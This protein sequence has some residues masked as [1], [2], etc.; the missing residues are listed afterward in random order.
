[1][2]TI[3][4]KYEG[5]WFAHDIDDASTTQYIGY[6]DPDGIWKIVKYDS[7]ADQ[8][9]LATD[10]NNPAVLNYPAAW[11]DRATLVYEYI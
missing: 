7:V 2:K 3:L 11:V 9:R 6:A 10:E 8:V 4:A 5:E 1:M